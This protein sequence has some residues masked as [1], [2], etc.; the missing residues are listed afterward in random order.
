MDIVAKRVPADKDGVRIAEIDEQKYRELLWCHR[1]LTDFWRIGRGYSRKLEAMGLFT[2]GDIAKASMD[3]YKEDLLYKAF[4]INAEL[5]IDHA[6]GYEPTEIEYIKKYRPSTNSLSSGQVLKKPYTCEKGELIVREMTELLVQ[7]LVRK[8]VVTK[9]IVL[10]I[11]YDRE[12][13][14]VDVPGKSIR[15]TV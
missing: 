5:L 8:G 2:M 11:G 6:W 14:T 13:L 12:S 10:T 15:D 4:G 7:D 1:P 3:P 9:Q